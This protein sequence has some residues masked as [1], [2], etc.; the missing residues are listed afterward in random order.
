MDIQSIKPTMMMVTS[1][2]NLDVSLC[3]IH[4]KETSSVDLWRHSNKLVFWT[5][6]VNTARTPSLD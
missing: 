4:R 2:L 3:D 1:F 6:K 5:M